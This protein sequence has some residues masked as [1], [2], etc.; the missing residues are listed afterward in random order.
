MIFKHFHVFLTF[1]LAL[2]RT[3][4]EKVLKVTSNLPSLEKV[5]LLALILA[6]TYI[7]HT[8][9]VCGSWGSRCLH[10]THPRKKFLSIETDLKFLNKP[11]VEQASSQRLVL[12][13][14]L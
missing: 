5:L 11:H 4:L 6:L 7:P 10:V 3:S 12:E 13:I 14:L 9:M 8:E 2:C 1:S